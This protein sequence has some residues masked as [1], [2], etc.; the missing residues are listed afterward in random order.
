MNILAI[1]LGKFY[2]M[3]C[4]FDTKTQQYSFWNAATTRAYLASVLKTRQIDLV[5]MEAG[6]SAICVRSTD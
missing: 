6:G 3:C 2:S 5:A 1:D 4:F